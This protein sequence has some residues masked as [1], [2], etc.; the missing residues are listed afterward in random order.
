LLTMDN[1]GEFIAIQ[2]ALGQR[3]GGRTDRGGLV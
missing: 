2:T 3:G 1:L